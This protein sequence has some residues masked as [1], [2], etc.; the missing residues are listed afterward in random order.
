MSANT[1]IS[2]TNGRRRSVIGTAFRMSLPENASTTRTAIALSQLPEDFQG[3]LA[4]TLQNRLST[5]KLAAAA[6]RMFASP[7]DGVA[8]EDSS[9]DV[10]GNLAD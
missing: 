9:H 1:S 6:L 10:S 4:K 5:V 2:L 8:A 7:S 3:E